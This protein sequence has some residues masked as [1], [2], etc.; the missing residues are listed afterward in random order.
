[1]QIRV[2]GKELEVTAATLDTL[3]NELDFVETLVATAVNQNFVRRDQ[4]ATTSLQEGDS[5]EI[6]MPRQGG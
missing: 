1:M 5:V 3:L 6:L 4:R 2:N